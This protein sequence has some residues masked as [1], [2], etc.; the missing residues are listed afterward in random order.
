MCIRDSYNA[1]HMLQCLFIVTCGIACFLCV[2]RVFEVRESS[3]SPRL[4]FCQILSFAASIAELAHGEK[5]RTHSITHSPSLF[6]T[7]ETKAFTS[8]LLPISAYSRIMSEWVCM[9]QCSTQHII[10]HFGDES[11]EATEY[12][13][14]DNQTIT[15][16]KYIKH[17]ITNQTQIHWQQQKHKNTQKPIPKTVHV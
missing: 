15:N 3:S 5:L 9:V 16:G 8:E 2:M 13:S 4:P 6:D 14:T 12:T 10:D 17:K 11:F 7:L 1:C